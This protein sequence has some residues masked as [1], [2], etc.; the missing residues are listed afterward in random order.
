MIDKETKDTIIEALSNGLL[1]AK[2]LSNLNYSMDDDI[3]FIEK[4]IEL[5]QE[6]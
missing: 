5:V 3:S 2:E 6:L 4:A 1:S